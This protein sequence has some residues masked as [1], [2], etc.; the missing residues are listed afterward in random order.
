MPG[1]RK[2]G[3]PTDHR[4]S[5]LR[6]MVTFLLENGKIETTVTRAKEVR[7]MT[8]K[9]ITLGK[10]DTLHSKRQVLSYVTKEDVVKKL[11]DEIAPKYADR[12]GGY[13]RIIKT[14]PRRGDAAEM[15]IKIKL[16]LK[17]IAFGI[18]QCKI[19]LTYRLVAA[20]IL[21]QCVTKNV[22][23]VLRIRYFYKFSVFKRFEM[24][25][26][27]FALLFCYAYFVGSYV[28][29]FITRAFCHFKIGFKEIYLKIG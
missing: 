26:Q 23:I 4:K 21:Y 27:L 3:R 29:S 15:C 13:C 9:M 17:L 20:K 25:N 22:K 19:A 16:C 24:F 7:A 1:S 11:F 28:I 10:N 2:L 18:I 12:N 14:G 5:M 8:E 6:G